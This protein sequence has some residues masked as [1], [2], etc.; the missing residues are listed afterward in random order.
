MYRAFL[1]D[2]LHEFESGVWRSTFLHILRI[3]YCIGESKLY[4]MN[5]QCVL[6]SSAQ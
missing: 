4:E 2:V 1:P 3:L 5:R 6:V